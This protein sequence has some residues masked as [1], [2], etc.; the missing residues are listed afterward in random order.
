MSIF[1]VFSLSRGGGYLLQDGRLTE[2]SS[3]SERRI[4]WFWEAPDGAIWIGHED[5][6]FHYRGGQV[7]QQR[8]AA[9]DRLAP[10]SDG[11]RGVVL[12]ATAP[13][14]QALQRRGMK[15]RILTP[16]SGFF[17]TPNAKDDEHSLRDLLQAL[18]RGAA[19]RTKRRRRR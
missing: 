11:Q 5:G 12:H 18:T 10:A 17:V 9:I 7:R 16:A 14:I 6:L 1:C 13:A 15:L 3:L 4:Q 8:N 2:L 19:S